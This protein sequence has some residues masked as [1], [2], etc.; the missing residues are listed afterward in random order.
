MA[1]THSDPFGTTERGGFLSEAEAIENEPM[2]WQARA[3]L[4][5]LA[6]LLVAGATWASVGKVDRMVVGRGR[7]ITTTP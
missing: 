2:P 5:V 3:T 7:L 4:Y 6:G 1:R